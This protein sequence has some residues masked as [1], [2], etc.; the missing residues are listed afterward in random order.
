MTDKNHNNLFFIR[1]FGAYTPRQ[2]VKRQIKIEEGLFLSVN[3]SS[4]EAFDRKND[5]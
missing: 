4:K 5:G 3:A 1:H 2:T